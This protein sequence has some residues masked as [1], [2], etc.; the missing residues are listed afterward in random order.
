MVR[1]S[2]LEDVKYCSGGCAI[3]LL[4]HFCYYEVSFIATRHFVTNRQ[5]DRQT[6]RRQPIILRGITNGY[7][8]K[9]NSFISVLSQTPAH[10]K[11]G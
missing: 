3:H 10:V 11:G 7:K 2:G 6:G 1:C 8:L 5:T 4:R 9:Q